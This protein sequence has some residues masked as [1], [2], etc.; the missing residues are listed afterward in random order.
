MLL[1]ISFLIGVQRLI[2]ELSKHILELERAKKQALTKG[3]EQKSG[4]YS[5]QGIAPV[6]PCR[7]RE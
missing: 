7:T 3:R 6:R 4:D 2:N 1:G 5:V